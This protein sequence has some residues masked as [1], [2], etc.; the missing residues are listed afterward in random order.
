MTYLPKPE[1][2]TKA[3]KMTCLISQLDTKNI[4]FQML[5]SYYVHFSYRLFTGIHY[6]MKFL[7][8]ENCILVKTVF[9]LVKNI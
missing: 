9:V 3:L 4:N 7:L 8:K 5:S 2:R 6:V 1:S